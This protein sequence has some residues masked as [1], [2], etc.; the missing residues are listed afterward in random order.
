MRIAALGTALLGASAVVLGVVAPAA[1]PAAQADFA[2]AAHIGTPAAHA[3]LLGGHG[4]N[5][6]GYNWSGYA[7]DSS[8]YTSV[9]S[10]WTVP[11]VSCNSSSDLYAPW[12]G[13]DGYGSRSVEQTGVATDCSSGS[14]VS[15]GWYEMYPASP[16]YYS[17]SSNPVRAG[18]HITASVNRTSSPDANGDYTYTLKLTDSTQNWSKTTTK[19]YAGANSSAEVI[20]ESPP[21]AYPD[22]H[23]VD[24]TGSTVDGNSLSGANPT[25]LDAYSGS[26]QETTA[27][28]LNGG[29]FS[30]AYDHE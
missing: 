19:K 22:F 20:I 16:I 12:V 18:D 9:S 30:I 3:N 26:T 24:F 23:S 11:S 28:R 29:D 21:A 27:G 17:T 25:A 15:S 4:F 10:S 1:A 13:L 8:T 5:Q 14:P 7:A 2:P 6:N